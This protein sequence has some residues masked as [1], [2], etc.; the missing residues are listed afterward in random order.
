MGLHLTVCMCVCFS[1]YCKWWLSHKRGLC[2]QQI[3]WLLGRQ[4]QPRL[5]WGLWGCRGKHSV[6]THGAGKG[7]VFPFPPNDKSEHSATCSKTVILWLCWPICLS[8]VQELVHRFTGTVSIILFVY[9]QR[10]REWE[11]YCMCLDGK[12][13]FGELRER[14]SLAKEWES[15]GFYQYRCHCWFYSSLNSIEGSL[16]RSS[17]SACKVEYTTNVTFMGY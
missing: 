17:I 6:I 3:C 4:T 16:H 2:C 7:A 14:L 12:R 13:T 15:I 8:Q 9:A 1:L 10:E 11:S 5:E